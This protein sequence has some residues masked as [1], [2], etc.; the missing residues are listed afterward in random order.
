MR[1]RRLPWERSTWVMMFPPTTMPTA[2][3]TP[4]ARATPPAV[5]RSPIHATALVPASFHPAIKTNPATAIRIPFR[6]KVHLLVG[7]ALTWPKQWQSGGPPTGQRDSD[8][9]GEDREKHQGGDG[10]P[11]RRRR[12]EEER[13]DNDLCHRQ[14][15][16]DRR[17]QPLRSS[18]LDDGRPG[19]GLVAE[20]GDPGNGEHGGECQ[21]KEKEDDLHLLLA[22]PAVPATAGMGRLGGQETQTPPRQSPEAQTLPHE[23]QF[24]GSTWKR[25]H[26]PLQ[27][28][29][30]APPAPVLQQELRF[31][32]QQ[33]PFSTSQQSWP[34]GQHFLPHAS[35]PFAHFTHSP[36]FG[37]AHFRP[38]SQHLRP[39]G[40]WS[41]S[42]Q[43]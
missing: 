20:L 4:R 19:S 18:E 37:L 30:S 28:H 24:W 36:V 5:S 10:A 41:A 23:P 6:T 14:S 32:L 26:V 13:S 34:F 16:G 3:A 15:Q 21:P 22:S 25:T 35:R 12:E 38:S 8:R 11:S 39:H 7:W 9:H 1:N 33:R 2:S 42:Q 17:R 43:R 29:F 40:A 27:I 31:V